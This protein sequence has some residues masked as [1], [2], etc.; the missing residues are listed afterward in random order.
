MPPKPSSSWTRPTAT[1]A[2]PTTSSTPAAKPD[3]TSSAAAA[4]AAPATSAAATPANP[5]AP[6]TSSTPATPAASAAPAPPVASSTL[7]AAAGIKDY[8][9]FKNNLEINQDEPI[10][11][12]DVN[13]TIIKNGVLSENLVR[14]L[15]GKQN[16]YLFTSMFA[17]T[18]KLNFLGNPVIYNLIQTLLSK[19]VTIKGVLTPVD[20]MILN[21]ID[22]HPSI[23]GQV[24]PGFF[25][26]KYLHK[27]EYG[28][29]INTT[30]EIIKS[31]L[32]K[33]KPIYNKDK[34]EKT[35]NEEY[36]MEVYKNKIFF[37]LLRYL[38]VEYRGILRDSTQ[39]PIQIIFVDDDIKQIISV[40]VEALISEYY[41]KYFTIKLVKVDSSND[42]I[43]EPDFTEDTATKGG[44]IK[45]LQ[46]LIKS[47]KNKTPPREYDDN[48][49]PEIRLLI[50]T[51]RAISQTDNPEEIQ[52]LPDNLKEC[53]QS[54][55]ELS[56]GNVDNISCNVGD[57]PSEAGPAAPPSAAAE[58]LSN[59]SNNDEIINYERLVDEVNYYIFDY[60]TI[61]KENFGITFF[62]RFLKY[63]IEKGKKFA[64]F[65]SSEDDS[66]SITPEIK[67]YLSLPEPK[68]D[69]YGIY[70]KSKKP[71]L[72]LMREITRFLDNQTKQ[73]FCFS[74]LDIAKKDERQ[75]STLQYIEIFKVE[76]NFK[77]ALNN[78]MKEY[79]SSYQ[80]AETYRVHKLDDSYYPELMNSNVFVFDFDVSIIRNNIYGYTLEQ[81]NRYLKEGWDDFIDKYFFS[82]LINYLESKGKQIRIISNVSREI[83]KA[84]LDSLLISDLIKPK[85]PNFFDDKIY[86]RP[87]GNDRHLNNSNDLLRRILNDGPYSDTP[88]EVAFFSSECKI[89]QSGFVGIKGYIIPDGN[90]K[91]NNLN[92]SQ[93]YNHPNQEYF[94]DSQNYKAYIKES[95]DLTLEQKKQ[96]Y[97]TKI[98][99]P[100]DRKK[101]D[102]LLNKYDVFVFDFDNTIT[103]EHI[104]NCEITSEDIE[105]AKLKDVLKYCADSYFFLALIEYLIFL[106]KVIMIASFGTENVIKAFLKK[107]RPEPSNFWNDKIFTPL[108]GNARY[109]TGIEGIPKEP[110]INKNDL[111]GEIIRRISRGPRIVLFDDSVVN[112]EA[113]KNLGPGY[114]GIL[115]SNDG[116]TKDF[117]NSLLNPNSKG[118]AASNNSHTKIFY[119]K[120]CK[121]GQKDA[122]SDCAL[123]ETDK[124]Q[125][126]PLHGMVGGNKKSKK[127]RQ[128]RKLNQYSNKK[129]SNKKSR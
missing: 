126:F 100:W 3:P 119:C 63:L 73:K 112:I 42:E 98:F 99:N 32:E 105:Q 16:V 33:L 107:I 43:N 67:K 110:P 94:Y 118:A 92:K 9:E 62:N 21:D 57:E 55:I 58:G 68:S 86:A 59:N 127:S 56:W 13:G 37:F 20:Y 76:S 101:L 78:A 27:L 113:V 106:D 74:N 90:L 75:L 51:R 123:C 103:N 53:L 115:V 25:Y 6:A 46:E 17:I 66:E 4:P 35:K 117:F 36:L 83:V 49:H 91:F 82:A 72:Q 93:L 18:V 81:V 39:K 24:Y 29:S 2:T 80:I 85:K 77:S 60:E 14:I 52:S 87:E 40:G 11:L 116:L 1:P 22:R 79:I 50:L 64:I 125:A 114:D 65:S 111:L 104:Y 19:G 102:S 23:W 8:E 61:K 71:F 44:L 109:V 122:S 97:V 12:I 26:E 47:F 7:A 28:T 128:L 5:A 41:G 108:K 88:Q 45:R 15:K 84:Y 30:S 120:I 121:Y 34:Y 69:N 124:S 89:I 96:I 70:I 95:T 31:E 129:K 10:Y 38:F 54:I 48:I